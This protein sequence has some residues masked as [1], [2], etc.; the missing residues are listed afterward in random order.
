MSPAN[1]SA[2][3]AMAAMP[4]SI[5]TSRLQRRS[6]ARTRPIVGRHCLSPGSKAMAVGTGRLTVAPPRSWHIL[7]HFAHGMPCIT[8]P[9]II[10]WLPVVAVIGLAVD[11]RKASMKAA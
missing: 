3:T 4:A 6:Q 11:W 2:C 7:H 5:E 9:G 1:G 8:M 10:M